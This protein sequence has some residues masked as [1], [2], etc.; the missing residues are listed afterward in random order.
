MT[1]FPWCWIPRFYP[2]RI[3]PGSTSTSPLIWNKTIRHVG[4]FPILHSDFAGSR[5]LNNTF[6]SPFDYNYTNPYVTKPSLRDA[7]VEVN[8]GSGYRTQTGTLIEQ[9]IAEFEYMLDGGTTVTFT[10]L[11]T[12]SPVEWKWEYESA[13][14]YWTHSPH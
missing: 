9:L 11:S 5:F 12:G 4:Q 1:M 8:V 10:D 13:P 3:I 7:V 2:G 6:T 14:G